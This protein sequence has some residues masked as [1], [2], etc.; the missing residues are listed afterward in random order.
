MLRTILE[1]TIELTAAA[2]VVAFVW[3]FAVAM[4]A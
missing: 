1:T 3:I 4:G 2:I